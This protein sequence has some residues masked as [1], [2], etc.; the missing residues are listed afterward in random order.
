MRYRAR[1]VTDDDF[2]F[3]GWTNIPELEK[4]GREKFASGEWTVYG[5]IVEKWD[6]V[7]NPCGYKCHCTDLPVWE[8]RNDGKP[9]WEDVDSLWAITTAALGYDGTSY[10]SRDEITSRIRDE[11]LRGILLDMWPDETTEQPA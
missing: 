4:E 6:D 7:A 1:I 3:T 2:D 8:C 11:Y 5:V 9:A 10:D